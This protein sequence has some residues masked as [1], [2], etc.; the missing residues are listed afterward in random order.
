MLDVF[1]F[2]SLSSAAVRRACDS[3]G[4]SFSKSASSVMI[5]ET[6]KAW[7]EATKLLYNTMRFRLSQFSVAG[8]ASAGGIDQAHRGQWRRSRS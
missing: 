8:S 5:Q 2:L 1:L 3:E 7:R 4:S 6:V